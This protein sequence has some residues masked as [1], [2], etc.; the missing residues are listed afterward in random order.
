MSL[1]E[2][3][4][5]VI[6]VKDLKYTKSRLKSILS[7]LERQTLTLR[8][9][10][11]TIEILKSLVPVRSILVLTPDERVLALAN[12]WG[13]LGLREEGRGL[14]R[15]LTQA[16]RWAVQQKFEAILVIPCDLPLLSRRDIEAIWELSAG[17]EDIA[18]M[19]PNADRSGTNALLVKPPG[20][21]RYRFGK[22]SFSHYQ[23]SVLAKQ[24]HFRVYTSPSIEFDLDRP[25]QCRLAFA[26][27]YCLEK[28]ID[29]SKIRPFDPD[30]GSS[31]HPAGR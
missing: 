29:E 21:L 27:P 24:I 28:A 7:L 6:P 18:V 25:E 2:K 26:K 19:A 5:V 1:A 13:V 4:L 8:I 20:I 23:T 17:E 30:W 22:N 9:L 15:A 12:H 10:S 16:T 31:P 3:V 11:R 14:N